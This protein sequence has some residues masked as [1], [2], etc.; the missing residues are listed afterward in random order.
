MTCPTPRLK[1][2]PTEADAPARAYLCACGSW[3]LKPRRPRGDG[4]L[5]KRDDG[6]WVGRVELTPKDGKRRWKKVSAKDR[7]EAIRKLKKLRADIDSGRI[8]VT[9][10]ATVQQWME[11]WLKDIHKRK[12]RPS[13]YQ[14]YDRI[15]RH[16]ITPH[17]GAKR[18]DRLTPAHVRQMHDAIDSSRAAQQAHVILQRALDDAEKEGIVTRN[19]A[20]V[21]D[22]PKHAT[23]GRQPLTADQ[24][25]KLLRS[26]IDTND[27]W[28]T[29]WAAALLLGARQ[30]ELLGLQWS[31]VDL[32]HGIADFS[33]QLQYV[34]QAH[35]CG[36][37]HSDGTWPCKRQRPGWC[38]QRKWD[39]PRG[40]EHQKLHRSLLLT[41]PKSAAGTRIVPLPAPLWV[42]LR[43]YPH[44]QPNPHGLVWH[45]DGN[46]VGPRDDYTNWQKALETAGL[47][48]APLHAARHTTATLLLEA[49]VPEDVRMAILG[50]NS[51]TVT[52]AYAHID[53]TLTRKAMTAL[54]GLLTENPSQS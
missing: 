4:S 6:L 3:H 43:Q 53:H 35:G 7:N 45:I 10:A 51:A 36:E 40:F 41:R 18:L 16:H 38:P 22:K 39:L 52:R 24:A 27:P 9:S 5:Y 13:T 34:P 47:P 33:W 17:I 32:E 48:A 54:D 8:A 50:H 14:S 12:I 37:R 29:R 19:V 42:M 21:V 26:A 11:R 46:P 15:I 28:A 2:Y 1:P 49:G 30:G 31:R 25:K 44:T 23:A 20:K